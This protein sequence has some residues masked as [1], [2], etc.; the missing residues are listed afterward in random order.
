MVNTHYFALLLLLF[1][2]LPLLLHL[3]AADRSIQVTDSG[4]MEHSL[5]A[6]LIAGTLAFWCEI[7][8]SEEEE[9]EVNNWPPGYEATALTLPHG[10]V[11]GD[12]L[13]RVS[14]GQPGAKR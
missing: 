8:F 13:G 11:T 14:P 7:V 5:H 6:T 2:S 4:V 12:S 9:A 10:L 3:T 1:L